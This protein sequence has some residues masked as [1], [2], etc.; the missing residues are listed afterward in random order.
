LLE[1]V[2]QNE[3]VRKQIQAVGA[4]PRA[5]KKDHL[6]IP[7]C[8]TANF[9]SAMRRRAERGGEDQVF[10][11]GPVSDRSDSAAA[12]M[13]SA[14]DPETQ[15]SSRCAQAPELLWQEKRDDIQERGILLHH[16]G[17][18]GG[19]EHGTTSA[20]AASSSL[21]TRMWMASTFAIC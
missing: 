11:V 12:N 14:R 10:R 6:K 19:S 9:T 16:A 7:S 2:T 17:V 13:V 21:P 1:K 8:A 15:A 18:G 4:R 3:T 20:M 5:G